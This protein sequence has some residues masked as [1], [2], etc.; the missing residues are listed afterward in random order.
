M[1]TLRVDKAR[2]IDVSAVTDVATRAEPAL[3]RPGDT[4]GTITLSMDGG[5]D[6]DWTRSVWVTSPERVF[7]A[8]GT[9]AFRR[10]NAPAFRVPAGRHVLRVTAHRPFA[11]LDGLAVSRTLERDLRVSLLPEPRSIH[12][13]V[14]MPSYQA[15][16]ASRETPRFSVEV[17]AAGTK[18]L[19]AK[20]DWRAMSLKETV[21]SQ[22]AL[23]LSLAPGA[24]RQVDLRPEVPKPG[25]YR[26]QLD[27]AGPTGTHS[28]S[29]SF[30][31]LGQ[32][33][34]PRLFY[35]KDQEEA[36]RRRIRKYPRLF[37]RYRLWLRRHVDKKGFLP[38]RMYGTGHDI[39]QESARWR[40]ISCLFSD[41]FL[42][43][44][45]GFHTGR[46]APLV[47]RP[48]WHYGSFQVN[49][50]FGEA[51][52]VVQDMLAGAS[53]E[54]AKE[55]NKLFQGWQMKETF[56]LESLLA[57]RE[58]LNP[59]TRGMISRQATMFTNYMTYF[60]AHAGEAGG[61]LWQDTR[62]F[63]HCPL[64]SIGRAFLVF[65]TFFREDDIFEAPFWRGLFTHHR[66]VM[67][68][69]DV[70]NYFRKPCL[71]G[72][73]DVLRWTMTGLTRNPLENRIYDL[74]DWVRKMDGSGPLGD[75]AL[76]EM[77]G[78]DVNVAI[79]MLVAFGWVDP[80][81]PK[82]DWEELPP[83]AVFKEEGNAALRSDW[84][85]TAT[86]L[87]FSCGV[88][89]TA[90]RQEPGHLRIAKGGRVLLG[91]RART[92]DHGQ[93]IP[94]WG[95]VVVVGD[96]WKDWWTGTAAYPRMAERHVVNRNAP[97]VLGYVFRDKRLGGL[98]PQ[99]Y[100]HCFAGGHGCGV[101]DI[102]LHSH[103]RHP[104][105][106][107][108]EIVAFETHPEFD[109]AAGD[110]SNA[111]PIET[112]RE[113]VRQVVFVRPNII[114]VFD[115]VELGPTDKPTQWIADCGK[116]SV[117][118]DRFEIGAGR[119]RL[120]GRV[121]LPRETKIEGRGSLLT[122]APSAAAKKVNYL[123]VMKTGGRRLKPVQ[124][125]LVTSGNQVGARINGPGRSVEVRF[126]TAGDIGGAIS[127][128]KLPSRPLTG[129]V[130]RSYSQ[131]KDHHLF[132]RWMKESRFACFI[133]KEDR[134][135]FGAMDLPDIPPPPPGAAPSD[136]VERIKGARAFEGFNVS[137]IPGKECPNLNLGTKDFMI[138][139]RI[140][141]ASG[142]P[143][144]GDR[145]TYTILSKGN[146]SSPLIQL[147]LRGAA[148]NGIYCRLWTGKGYRD[149][150]PARN[151][152]SV[153]TDGEFHTIAVVRQGTTG[154]IYVDG[155]EAGRMADY[156]HP[157]DNTR[158]FIL[159]VIDSG[160]YFQGYMDD[161]RVWRFDNG[162]PAD[163]T[164]AIALYKR[165]RN[166]V[167]TFL[168]K[169]GTVN[170]SVW[171]LDEEP[172]ANVARDTGP[173]GYDLRN[174]EE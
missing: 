9:E 59:K 15:V 29:R 39:T 148:Y 26:L 66:Y 22:G 112:V 174:R 46:I 100:E 128:P 111:W 134:K 82:V 170:Y 127:L 40:A 119:A 153:F 69:K 34:Y 30:V 21:V 144:A 90:Y 149:L 117:G 120:C 101:Y 157:V 156:R 131:W 145:D 129:K 137:S 78:N 17:T 92:G 50:Q 146:W 2:W 106:R 136:A 94:T 49:F 16:F 102:I 42:E 64:H 122:V 152:A 96:A 135:K 72:A 123:V 142:L 143:L 88:R 47:T 53:P 79:P 54:K 75:K 77:L 70:A 63:C 171:R 105:S 6:H 25:V 114:V 166:E 7:L 147:A 23:S 36:I 60:G 151:M 41:L 1:H 168:K 44:K 125:E 124:A 10:A 20:L 163:Y 45:A 132:K 56:F 110:A 138:Q 12:A 99:V 121:L 172:T 28:L 173:N 35:R 68:R 43:K 19:Q 24:K 4:P 52:P 95:N 8:N 98:I 11:R 81:A 93:P 164:K 51:I 109:Y 33:T 107:R 108:G 85:E 89:D 74:G 48:H 118:K 167:P 71:Q 154:I 3:P 160:G 80:E 14:P 55:V 139:A 133:S 86:E 162:I 158:P 73:N 165:T 62:G 155:K 150:K 97:E 61:N 5:A 31:K 140:K 83:S 27:F 91:T 130:D 141:L 76:D 116:L 67:P 58:P 18:P 161:V 169:A 84:T 113:L 87:F 57:M 38:E 65:G 115:R 104:F 13:G 32:V 103:S 159:G 126:N 37:E